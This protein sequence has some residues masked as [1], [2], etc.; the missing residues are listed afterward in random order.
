MAYAVHARDLRNLLS[1][2]AKL[3]VLAAETRAQGDQLLY[4]MTAEALEKRADKL[5]ATLPNTHH[6]EDVEKIA[7]WRHRPVDVII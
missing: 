7:P 1:V 6:D 5:S 3:R 2:A 4:L